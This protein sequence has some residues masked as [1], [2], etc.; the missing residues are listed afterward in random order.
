VSGKLPARNLVLAR[1]DKGTTAA[2]SHVNKLPSL[3]NFR[4]AF[5]IFVDNPGITPRNARIIGWT[6]HIHRGKT[7]RQVRIIITRSRIFK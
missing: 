4:P 5:A 1:A 2:R 3:K 7:P 6:S